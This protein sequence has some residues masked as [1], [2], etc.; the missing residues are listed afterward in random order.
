M[1][2][3][4][5]K[6]ISGLKQ[7]ME[8]VCLGSNECHEVFLYINNKFS[9][10]ALSSSMDELESHYWS[11]IQKI[12][13]SASTEKILYAA[14]I[15]LKNTEFKNTMNFSISKLNTIL[16]LYSVETPGISYPYMYVGSKHASFPWHVEDACLFSINLIHFGAPC[17]W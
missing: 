13:S 9:L 10:Q 1:L 7:R 15:P 16:D 17:V 2:Y 6:Y 8:Y 3:V 12:S 5:V 4:T 14:G 11:E